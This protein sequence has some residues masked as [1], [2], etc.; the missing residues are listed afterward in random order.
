MAIFNSE[1]FV[2]QR[3]SR[4]N[5][6]FMRFPKM[7]KPPKP[8]VSILKLSNFGWF[9]VPPKWVWVQWFSCR[10]HTR[11]FWVPSIFLKMYCIYSHVLHIQ[12]SSSSPCEYNTT[13]RI[14]VS[15]QKKAASIQ[16]PWE[17]LTYFTCQWKHSGS[18]TSVH[19]LGLHV[20]FFWWL[21]IICDSKGVFSYELSGQILVLT[22]IYNTVTSCGAWNSATFSCQK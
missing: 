13:W 16:R 3:V 9:G 21:N 18:S 1:L 10:Q 11:L 5:W 8:W 7:G 12:L 6:G 15:L 14:C 22:I 4:T 2:Y 20:L 17:D 19:G